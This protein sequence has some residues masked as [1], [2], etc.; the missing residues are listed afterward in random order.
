MSSAPTLTTC[1]IPARAAAPSRSG[2]AES[3][4]PIS[5]S[6]HSVVVTSATPATNPSAISDSIARP[7][8]PTAWNTST[9]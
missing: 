9:S 3:T 5:S 2:P 4:P 8:L 6:H 7:P 1:G